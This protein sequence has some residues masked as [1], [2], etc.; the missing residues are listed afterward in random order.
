MYYVGIDIAK[1]LHVATIL[2]S[3]GDMLVKPFK[4]SNDQDGFSRFLSFVEPFDKD[5]LIL[6]LESTAHY[7]YNFVYFFFDLGYKITLI[8][9]L[10]ISALRKSKIRK[11]KTDKTDSLLIAQFI[12]DNQVRILQPQTIEL[13]KL[14][15]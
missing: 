4:F 11:T 5:N 15:S 1:Q 12:K 8:N 10:Q 2:S 13:I 9:P 14:R 7:S 3:D 6:G